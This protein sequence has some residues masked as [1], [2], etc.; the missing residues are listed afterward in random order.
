MQLKKGNQN[1]S[2]S[3]MQPIKLGDDGESYAATS[4]QKNA[5]LTTSITAASGTS[6][7]ITMKNEPV[8]IPRKSSSLTG[9]HLS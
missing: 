6:D 3:L 9:S 5:I 8:G 7:Y 4:A 2:V 1:Y